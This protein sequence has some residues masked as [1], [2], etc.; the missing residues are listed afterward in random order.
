MRVKTLILTTIIFLTGFFAQAQEDYLKIDITVNP[1]LIGRGEQGILKLKITP[2][3]D[4]KISSIPGFMIKFDDNQNLS[5][6]KVFY[7]A[8]ELDLESKQEKDT[9]YYEFGKEIPLPFKVSNNSLLG[10]QKISGEII[11]TAIFKDNWSLKTYQKFYAD[12]IS[13]KDNKVKK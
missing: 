12:F 2:R 11:F 10:K 1:S 9:V 4:L 6:P 3:S 5:F 7:T 13:K 8:S